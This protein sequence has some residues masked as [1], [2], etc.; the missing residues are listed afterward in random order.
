MAL[1]K[2][3]SRGEPQIGMRRRIKDNPVAS[4]FVL[5]YAIAWLPAILGNRSDVGQVFM[6]ITQ[7]GPAIVALFLTWYAT[8]KM[9]YAAQAG[10]AR[11][12]YCDLIE[13]MKTF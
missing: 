3:T 8:I 10:A 7:F 11:V 12:R 5:A 9:I 13:G 2:G 1:F 6:M 4:F